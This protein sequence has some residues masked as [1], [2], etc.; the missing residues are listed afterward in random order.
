M[1]IFKI[2][3]NKLLIV[4]N[5]IVDHPLILYYKKKVKFINIGLKLLSHDAC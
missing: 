5:L 2:I 3:W 4:T 1:I